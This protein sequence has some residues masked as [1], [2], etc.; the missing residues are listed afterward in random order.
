MSH[1]K[2]L[3]IKA[4]FVD[5]LGYQ[6]T[7]GTTAHP[8]EMDEMDLQV[9]RGIKVSSDENYCT[10][11]L[12]SIHRDLPYYAICYDLKKCLSILHGKVNLVQ[13]DEQ[14]MMAKRETKVILVCKFSINCTIRNITFN[15]QH[16]QICVLAKHGK[17]TTDA[18]FL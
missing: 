1:W 3:K 10:V 9:K 4:A 7:L 8:A 15:T 17:D 6:G 14:G 11:E 18:H 5:I 16:N 12:E 13:L 2:K